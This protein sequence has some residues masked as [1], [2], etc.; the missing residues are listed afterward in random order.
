MKI[1]IIKNCGRAFKGGKNRLWGQQNFLN[2]SEISSEHV[3]SATF[4]K[5]KQ[6][7]IWTQFFVNGMLSH[8]LA[9]LEREEEFIDF[10][11]ALLPHECHQFLQY[12]VWALFFDQ[13]KGGRGSTTTLSL[14]KFSLWI[15]VESPW[16]EGK[17]RLLV[18]KLLFGRAL[19]NIAWIIAPTWPYTKFSP[20][21]KIIQ[22]L[23]HWSLAMKHI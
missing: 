14:R 1:L 5:S 2:A 7:I 13:L 16:L 8:S 4:N 15:I 11:R 6:N 17:T 10:Y 9:T 20:L 21:H 22:T 23:G 19:Q 18:N 12:V 3:N